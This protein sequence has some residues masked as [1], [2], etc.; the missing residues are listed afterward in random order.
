M[1]TKQSQPNK[2]NETLQQT[3]VEA[4]NTKKIHSS[5]LGARESGKTTFFKL[6]QTNIKETLFNEFDLDNLFS[7]IMD[8]VYTIC[9]YLFDNQQTFEFREKYWKFQEAVGKILVYFGG[10]RF[11]YEGT[12][13]F[14]P[15]LYYLILD[16]L[17]DPFILETA[18][19]HFAELNLLDTYL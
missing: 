10:K 3:Q 18:E 12:K 1:G 6:F 4:S 11:Q 17:K 9:K 8:A 7:N 13:C 16:L 2:K 15:E 14:T 5:F 19:K